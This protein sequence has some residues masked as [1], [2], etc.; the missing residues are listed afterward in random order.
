MTSEVDIVNNAILKIRGNSIS[1]L[2][3]AGAEGEYAA[4]LYPQ[5]RDAVLADHPWNFAIT[6]AALA[7]D[8]TAPAFEYSYRFQLPSDCLRV[9]D[10]YDHTTPWKVEG[11]YILTDEAE[12]NIIYIK[13]VETT[14]L[15]SPLFV[16]ALATRLAASLA[17]PIAGDQGL[18]SSLFQEYIQ[19][20]RRAK[21]ADAQEGSADNIQATLWWDIGN[22][23]SESIPRF[24][25]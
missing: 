11:R 9:W 7:R 10:V 5:I 21:T 23:W 25:V 2:G 1:A 6:R 16:E 12:C 22:G 15:F 20:I 13:R 19:V 3:E 18:K 4:V 8:A 24:T 14:G 17:V